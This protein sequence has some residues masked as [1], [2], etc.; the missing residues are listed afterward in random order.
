L[1]SPAPDRRLIGAAGLTAL[2]LFGVGNSL[3]A[4]DSPDSG[5]P[6][7]E[8]LR[9]YADKSS[10]IEV[11]VSLSFA[12]L[13]AFLY[14]AVGLRELLARF[15]ADGVLATTAFAGAL[16]AALCG[17]GSQAINLAGGMLAS[18]GNLGASTARTAF[19][20]ARVFGFYAAPVGFGLLLIAIAAISLRARAI[21]PGWLARVTIAVGLALFTPVAPAAL[22]PA[23][24]LLIVV[25][26]LVIR[27]PDPEAAP[28]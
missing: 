13:A 18:N 3:W 11:G 9:F 12:A 27:A 24:L 16:V 2:L 5:A 17:L 1:R 20:L 15:D 7:G 8:L 26:V 19:E 22:H 10:S 25:A 4:F 28:A 6:A 23:V 14:F 21:M